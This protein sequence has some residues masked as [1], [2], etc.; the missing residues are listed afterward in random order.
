M[1][2]PCTKLYNC[3]QYM[4]ISQ[5][6][7]IGVK[8]LILNMVNIYYIPGTT[9]GSQTPQKRMIPGQREPGVTGHGPKPK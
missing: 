2:P 4:H 3:L 7:S 8:V 5:R 6:G 9:Y 1:K